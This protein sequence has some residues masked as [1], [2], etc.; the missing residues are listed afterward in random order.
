MQYRQHLA[1]ALVALGS[2]DEAGALAELDQARLAADALDPGGPR[3]A[4]VLGLR[5][6]VETLAGRPA[7][8]RE[9]LLSA[10]AIWER[11]PEAAA[12]LADCYGQL[13]ALSEGLGDAVAAEAWRLRQQELERG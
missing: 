13:A 10:A 6:Q 5:A 2:G 1:S 4:E 11:F 9:A 3:V 7:E 8:A 12:G